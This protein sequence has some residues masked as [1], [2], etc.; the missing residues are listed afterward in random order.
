[1]RGR[2][3]NKLFSIIGLVLGE[4]YMLLTILAPYHK[5]PPIPLKF[6][7]PPES[8][9]P[10]DV[11]VPAGVLAFKLI[12]F[13]ALFGVF[14]ALVGLGVGLLLTGLFAKRPPPAR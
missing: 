6:A 7:V 10:A 11:A 9:L 3:F 8:P 5:G 13:A 4:I 12:V 14:G 1:M 2:N